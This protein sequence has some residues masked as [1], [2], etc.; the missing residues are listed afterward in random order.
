MQEGHVDDLLPTAGCVS[1][2]IDQCGGGYREVMY[3][4][5]ASVSFFP[6]PFF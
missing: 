4:M 6:F 3:R 2:H 1:S 5:N